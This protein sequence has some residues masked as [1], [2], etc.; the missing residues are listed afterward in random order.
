MQQQMHTCFLLEEGDLKS[1]KRALTRHMIREEIAPNLTWLTLSI[2]IQIGFLWV[3]VD[4][5]D[6]TPYILVGRTPHV[7]RPESGILQNRKK[8]KEGHIMV[9]NPQIHLSALANEFTVASRLRPSK[10]SRESK[11]TTVS[12]SGLLFFTTHEV[13]SVSQDVHSIHCETICRVLVG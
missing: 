10:S 4:M 6:E 3:G 7:H 1:A 11:K 13:S 9:R 12:C 8:V 2:S 5:G